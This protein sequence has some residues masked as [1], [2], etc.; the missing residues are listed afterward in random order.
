[1]NGWLEFGYEFFFWFNRIVFFYIIA[2]VFVYL[3]LFLTSAFNLRKQIGIPEMQYDEMLTTKFAP[4]LSIIVPVYNEEIGAVYSIRSLLGINYS[5][6]EVIVVNDGSK[7][8]SL[9]TIIKEFDMFE[10]QEKI[11]WTGL[12]KGTKPVR[13]VYGSRLH[14]NL[15]L[16]DKENGGK[17]DALNAGILMSKY[18]YFVSIDGDTILDTNA[19]MKVMKPII[20]AKPGEEIIASGG[21]VGIA[22]GNRIDRGYLNSGKVSLVR[23]PLVVMQVIEYIRAFLMGRMSLSRYN[24]LL[25]VS[26]A[27]SVFRKDW[28]IKAGGYDTETVGE[29]MELVVRLHRLI[30]ENKSKARIA[31][32]PDPVC[33]TEA[34]ESLSVLYNQRK[35]WHKGLFQS[36]Y[37]HKKMMLNPKYGAI[38]MLAFP[39]FF[40]IEFLGPAIELLGYFVVIFGLWFNLINIPYAVL[41]SLV[42]I[43]YGSFLSMGALLLEEWS[44]RKYKKLS[45]FFR[46]FVYALTES[47]WYRPLMSISRMHSLFELGRRKRGEWGRMTRKAGVLHHQEEVPAQPK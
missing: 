17:A 29:D 4:P 19:I 41:F 20:E 34:P 2:V 21:S 31:F 44:Q 28:V 46:L 16:L 40:F 38:G 26:G 10:M 7:D 1:M 9:E 42:M 6:Y 13:K 11:V 22:N 45:D 5:Q 23:H 35:R 8:N 24:I 15:F 33:W 25:I 43:I 36:L 18:P 3:V 37:R 27:F 47:F 12:K 14:S 30:R 39:Y 32:L